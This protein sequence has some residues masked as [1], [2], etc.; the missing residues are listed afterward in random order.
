[1][2]FQIFSF[3]IAKCGL[4]VCVWIIFCWKH[5]KEKSLADGRTKWHFLWILPQRKGKQI[6]FI[7]EK[8]M[9]VSQALFKRDRI[10]L[11][12][13]SV[14]SGLLEACSLPDSIIPWIWNGVFTCGAYCVQHW[15]QNFKLWWQ[16][17]NVQAT[18][19]MQC[20]EKPFKD[21]GISHLLS[22]KCTVYKCTTVA[23]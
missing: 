5:L 12:F 10:G 16:K 9:V 21:S 13:S 3:L 2:G 18:L 22:V 23:N 7:Y 6:Y 19:N 20:T 8:N 4:R 15:L 17:K 14:Y 11:E 1:M